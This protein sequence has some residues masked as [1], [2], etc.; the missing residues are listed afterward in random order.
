MSFFIGALLLAAPL[1]GADDVQPQITCA[2][3]MKSDVPRLLVEVSVRVS[4]NELLGHAEAQRGW[5]GMHGVFFDR[6]PLKQSQDAR[7]KMQVYSNRSREALLYVD[8][9]REISEKRHYQGF[10]K[11]R[12]IMNGRIV[13]V[14]CFARGGA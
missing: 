10:F 5:Y 6:L 12:S 9:E 8:F 11:M 7:S 13:P 4:A 3:S 1:L 14:T 2:T